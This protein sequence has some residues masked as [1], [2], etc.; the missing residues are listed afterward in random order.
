MREGRIMRR[1]WDSVK[2]LSVDIDKCA[3]IRYPHFLINII[4]TGLEC[5]FRRKVKV[6]PGAI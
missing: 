6:V 1:L 2:S 4:M 3:N 5:N